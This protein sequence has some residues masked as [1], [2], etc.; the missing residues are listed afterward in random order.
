M[1]NIGIGL[2]DNRERLSTP[3]DDEKDDNDADRVWGISLFSSLTILM[4]PPYFFDF[5]L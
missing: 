5:T 3:D 1:H 2:S 4:L